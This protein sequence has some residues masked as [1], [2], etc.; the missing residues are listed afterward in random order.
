MSKVLSKGFIFTEIL[1][2]RKDNN[3]C[4]RQVF[5]INTENVRPN[6]VTINHGTT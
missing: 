2:L 3:L 1:F 5:A 6:A 4:N